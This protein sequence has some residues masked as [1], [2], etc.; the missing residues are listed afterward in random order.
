MVNDDVKP[1]ICEEGPFT[2]PFVPEDLALTVLCH[3]TLGTLFLARGCVHVNGEEM[4]PE[5]F[6]QLSGVVPAGQWKTSLHILPGQ[7]KE[8]PAGMSPAACLPCRALLFL[9]AAVSRAVERARSVSLLQL[10]LNNLWLRSVI[11]L[12]TDVCVQR[13]FIHSE[14]KA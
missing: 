1:Q 7:V 10:C 11:R 14:R 13:H 9:R 12:P 4:T 5:Q 2:A 8:C 3:D 6:E